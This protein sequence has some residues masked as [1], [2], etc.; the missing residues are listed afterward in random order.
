MEEAAQRA[1]SPPER[2]VESDGISSESASQEARR[3]ST[4]REAARSSCRRRMLL[5]WVS[6]TQENPELSYLEDRAVRPAT[7]KRY[8][9]SVA[10]FLKYCR[11]EKLPTGTDTDVDAALVSF[12]NSLYMM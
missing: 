1:A 7:A 8:R 12:L 6:S 2:H 3:T 10:H 4:L 5:D 11:E 9:K